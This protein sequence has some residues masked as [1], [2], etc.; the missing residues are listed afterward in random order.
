M[1]TVNADGRNIEPD[2]IAQNLLG[3]Q[4]QCQ[5]NTRITIGRQCNEEPKKVTSNK[6]QDKKNMD[7]EQG[8]GQGHGNEFE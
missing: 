8:L 7:I 2:H 5:Y 4:L 6:E 3:T 1:R